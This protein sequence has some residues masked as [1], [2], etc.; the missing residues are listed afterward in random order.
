MAGRVF[1]FLGVGSGR[2]VRVIELFKI[3]ESIVILKLGGF[4]H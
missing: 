1:F 3:L 4:T 2:R